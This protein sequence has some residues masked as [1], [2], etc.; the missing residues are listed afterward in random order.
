MGIQGSSQGR[1]PLVL[2]HIVNRPSVLAAGKLTVYS[3]LT[4]MFEMTPVGNHNS[5][6]G[7]L[8]PCSENLFVENADFLEGV[9]RCDGIDKKEAVASEHVLF[10]QSPDRWMVKSQHARVADGPPGKLRRT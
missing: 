10:R 5:G 4:L 8:T 6:T 3:N 7:V 9:A 2:S 1:G